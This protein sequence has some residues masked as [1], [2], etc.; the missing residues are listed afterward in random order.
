MP[1]VTSVCPGWIATK[2]LK[3]LPSTNTGQIRNAPPAAK[4]TPPSQRIVSPSIVHSSLR[5]VYAGRYAFRNPIIPNT[6][7]HPTVAA[8]LAH[9]GTK[10]SSSEKRHTR[11]REQHNHKHY[12]CR[13]REERPETT[14]TQNRET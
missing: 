14:P 3:R 13:V 8:T 1:L 10:I 5:S 4:S 7:Q 11:E 12:Q 2:P 9:A 6:G